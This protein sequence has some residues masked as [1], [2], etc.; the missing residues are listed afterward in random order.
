M[1]PVRSSPAEIS[2]DRVVTVGVALAVAAALALWDTRFH[3]VPLDG[4]VWRGLSGAPGVLRVLFSL[5]AGVLAAWATRRS[6]RRWRTPLIALA[7]AGAPL[8]PVYTGHFLPLLAL[9]GPV[10]SFVAGAAVLLALARRVEESEPGRVPGW[11]LFIVAFALYAALAPRIPGAAGPQGDEPHYLTMAQSLWS[12]RDLDLTDEFANAE[13]A[14]FYAGTLSGHISENSPPGRLYSI[15]SPGL[16]F[17]ILPGYAAF[18][19]RGAQLLLSALAALAGVLVY[20][21]ARDAL[22][23]RTALVTWALFALTPPVPIYAVTLYPET[24]ALAATAYFLWAGR[25]R[26][27]WGRALGAALVAGALGWLHSKF[28]PLGALGLL[29]T[30]MRPCAWR[31]RAAAAF[32]FAVLVAGVLWYFHALYGSASLFAAIGPADLDLQRLPRNVVALFFDRQFGLFAIGPVWLLA[33][34]GIV[35]LFRTRLGDTIRVLALASVPIA[36]GAAYVGWWGGSAPPARYVIPALPAIALAAAPAIRARKDLA[37][38]LGACGFVLVGLA[39]QAPRILHNRG[40]GESLLLRNL[41]PAV[42]LDAF[43]PSFFDRDVGTLVLTLTLLAAFALAWRFR[44]AGLAVGLAGYVLVAGTLRDR[45]LVD[46]RLATEDLVDRW[47]PGQWSG[48]MG[49]PSLRALGMPLELQRGPW[50]LAAGEQRNSRRTGLPPGA[51]RVE[52]RASPAEPGPFRL[53]ASLYA[54]ELSLGEAVLTDAQPTA[55]FPLLLPGGVRQLGLTAMGEAGRAR[56]DD[57]VVVPE[58]LVPRHR[59]DDYPYPLRAIAELYRVGGPLVRATAVDRSEPEDGGFR[60]QGGE[61][62]FLVDGPPAAS[63]RI[64]VRRASPDA[65]DELRWGGRVVPLGA[66]P[67]SVLVLPMAEG[68]DLG[69]ASVV[70]VRLRARDAWIRFGAEGGA[71]GATAVP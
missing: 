46:R 18:G 62:A 39:A 33:L 5:A 71:P 30:L 26:T 61:G 10:L 2:R 70:S 38:V 9:Q 57:V 48:P 55:V 34:P 64:D 41:V 28:V 3:V 8:V 36:A 27:G 31:V 7:L 21:V 4:G 13:Y 63:V 29:F 65:G 11:L 20:R 42:D 17:L 47:E 35:M 12:D 53:D 14:R 32:L 56:L 51:Y 50:I 40:D 52:L 54:G 59:R 23:D 69:R 16:A 49:P 15:H 6:P 44:A 25:G 60:L 45:P 68:E 66:G 58:A 67:A 22:D 24:P 19:H 1:V 37:V 43:L